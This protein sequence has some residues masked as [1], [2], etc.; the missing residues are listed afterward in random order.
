VV[1]PNTTIS[2]PPQPYGI[3]SLVLN[4]QTVSNGAKD[5]S[6]TVN[7]IHLKVLN[8]GLVTLE[9]IV[10]SAHSDAHMP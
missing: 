8:G 5:T 4:E 7:A 9:V 3:V 1:A 6:G 10:T 2:V